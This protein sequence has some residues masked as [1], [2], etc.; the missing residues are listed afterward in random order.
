M[1]I[2][3]F[4]TMTLYSFECSYVGTLKM[5]DLN[6]ISTTILRLSYDRYRVPLTGY[7]SYDSH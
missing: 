7:Q 6:Y 4:D 3:T 2:H 5:Y 1:L